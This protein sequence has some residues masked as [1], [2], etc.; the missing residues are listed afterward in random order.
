MNYVLGALMGKKHCGW[1][2][3]KDTTWWEHFTHQDQLGDSPVRWKRYAVNV[4]VWLGEHVPLWK[5]GNAWHYRFHIPAD[6][7]SKVKDKWCDT[8]QIGDVVCDCKGEHLR[9]VEFLDKDS[10][11]LEDG[12]QCSLY[13]CC[14]EPDL[15][16]DFGCH[17]TMTM[18]EYWESVKGTD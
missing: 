13:H 11:I 12:S 14:D 8:K 10:V 7:Y 6:A 2:N 4:Q 1:C 5:I 17:G 3:H 9:I 16:P 15:G 18:V